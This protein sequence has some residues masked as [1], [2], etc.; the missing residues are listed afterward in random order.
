MNIDDILRVLY[1]DIKMAL[2]AVYGYSLPLAFHM[3]L[4]KYTRIHMILISIDMIA[5]GEY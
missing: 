4:T 3:P 1:P 5:R 2:N